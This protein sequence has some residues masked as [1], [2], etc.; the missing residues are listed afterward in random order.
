MALHIKLIP[1]ESKRRWLK[2]DIQRQKKSQTFKGMGLR[3]IN[4]MFEKS[5]IGHICYAKQ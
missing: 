2:R 3:G 5:V 4:R 1:T